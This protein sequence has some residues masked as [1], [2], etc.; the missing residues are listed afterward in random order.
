MSPD[1]PVGGGGTVAA[2]THVEVELIGETGDAEHLACDIVPDAEADFTHGFLGMGT[3][4]ARAILGHA[5]GSVV[6]YRV[7]DV[8]EVRILKV[9]CAVTAPSVG[10]EARRQAVI[11]EAVARSEVLN[12]VSFAL[13]AGSKWGDYNPEAIAPDRETKENRQ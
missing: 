2:G 6:P 10:L 4:L 1:D 9:S 13:A 3:P 12:D 11:S 8:V 5:A 7:G